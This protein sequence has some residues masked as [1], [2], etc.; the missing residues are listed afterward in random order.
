MNVYLHA[1]TSLAA[2]VVVS[3]P[4]S[5]ATFFSDV[6]TWQSEV[7]AFNRDTDYGA[8]FTDIGSL[9]L[10]DGTT[11]SFDDDVNIRT[12]GSSRAT[13]SGGYSGQVL[14]AT[15]GTSLIT[16][17]TSGPV[18]AFGFFAQP[19]P[20]EIVTITLTLSDGSVLS[21]PVNGTG[22]ARFFGWTGMPI[23]GFTLSS[24]QL[25]AVGDFYSAGTGVDPILEPS[26]WLMLLVGFGALGGVIRSAKRRQRL[27]I[28]YA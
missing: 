3:T 18:S 9:T 28:S 14:Y 10:E 16:T 17:F 7:G 11:L 2:L 23:S 5:A 26:S 4:A 21:Q 22:G 8:Q 12:V 24:P 25:F 19:D 20:F 27:T 13:W 1:C 15:S 6:A